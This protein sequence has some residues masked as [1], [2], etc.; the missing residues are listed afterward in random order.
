MKDLFIFIFSYIWRFFINNVVFEKK[1]KNRV[2]ISYLSV[3]PKKPKI[4]VEYMNQIKQIQYSIDNKL[5][6][7]NLNR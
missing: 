2:D 4:L 3:D 7:A 5:L 1:K 6:K